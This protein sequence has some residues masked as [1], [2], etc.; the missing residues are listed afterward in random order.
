MPRDARRRDALVGG[1][2]DPSPAGIGLG[3]VWPESPL[4]GRASELAGAGR[5]L[6]V[7]FLG[8]GYFALAESLAY[9][10]GHL[11]ALNDTYS[12]G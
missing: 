4:L 10:W 12:P 1:N 9:G 11:A 6:P 7:E 3:V 5:Y 8:G 2:S